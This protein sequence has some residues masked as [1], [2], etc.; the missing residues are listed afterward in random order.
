MEQLVNFLA[1]NHTLT[2]ITAVVA[3]LV[4]IFSF[5]LTSKKIFSSNR[6]V[7]AGRDINAPI[8]TGDINKNETCTLALLANI[9]TIIGVLVSIATLYVSYLALV[10]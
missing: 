5:K 4:L 9:A 6:G 2:I 10:K 8:M 3:L 7:S 1:I